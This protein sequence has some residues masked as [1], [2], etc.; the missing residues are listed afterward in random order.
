MRKSLTQ[1]LLSRAGLSITLGCALMLS[2]CSGGSG[3]V[4]TPT[5]NNSTKIRV[6]GINVLNGQEWQ[7]NRALDIQFSR[8]VDFSTVN[9]NTINLMDSQGVS[10]TG[11]FS[12][13]LDSQ[14]N[15]NRRMIRFQ[16]NCPTQADFSDAGL[17][18]D[19]TYRLTVKGSSTGGV[20]LTD[21]S[22]EGLEI[23]A[24]VE[25]NTP[26]SVD[27][28]VLF[29][30]T[31]A[32]PPVVVVRGLNDD[33]ALPASSLVLGGIEQ[34]FL[35]SVVDQEGR[36]LFDVPLN[37]YS[38]EENQLQV[39]LQFNQPID[40][41]AENIN[42]GL[43][44]LQYRENGATDFTDMATELELLANCTERGASLRVSPLGLVPQD[45]DLRVVLFQGFKD[46]T[47]NPTESDFD[48][49]SVMHTVEAGDPNALHPGIDNPEVDDLFETFDLSGNEIGS[50]E[51]I[52]ANSEFPAANW[53]DGVL[54]ASFAFGGTGGP[55]G[56]FD[57]HIPQGTERVL[58][59]VSDT[60]QGGPDGAPV[61]TQAVINGVVDVRNL[62]VPKGSKLRIIGP[63]TCTILASG[64]VEILGEVSVNGSSN[65]GV[66]TL[67]TTNQPEEGAKGNAGGGDGGTGSFLTTQSTPRGGRGFGAFNVP[68]LGGEGGESGYATGTKHN[69]RAGGGG[70]GR[71]GPDIY[72]RHSGATQFYIR[73]QGLVGL[74]A[75]PGAPGGIA[76]TGAISQDGRAQGG[77]I[78]PAPFIDPNPDNNFLGTMITSE[79]DVIPG[80]LFDVHAGAGGGGGGDAVKSNSFP[81]DPFTIIGDEKGAGGGGGAGGLRILAIGDITIGSPGDPGFI[82]ADGGAGGGGENTSYFDR[83]GGGSGGGSGGHVVISTANNLT[84]YGEA[85]ASGGPGPWYRDAENV[86]NHSV[87]PISLVGGQGGAGN[88]SDGGAN[89]NGPTFW[90]CDGIPD[91]YFDGPNGNPPPSGD[92]CFTTQ[93]DS[94]DPSGFNSLAA[95]GDGSPGILQLHVGDYDTQLFFPDVADATLYSAGKDITTVCAPPPLGWK[96]PGAAPDA[97]VPFFGAQ[98]ESQSKWIPLGLARINTGGGLDNLDFTFAGTDALGAIPNTGSGSVAAL[99]AILGPATM[100]SPGYT[101][102][103][104]AAALAAGD[105][106]YKENPRLLTGFAVKLEDSSDPLVFQ[107]YYITAATYA[108]GADEFTFMV[109]PNGPNPATFVAAGTIEASLIQRFVGV[110]TNGIQDNYSDL[111]EITVTFQAAQI[112]PD[113]GLVINESTFVAD[114]DD[115]EPPTNSTHWDL[116]RVNFNFNIDK[117]GLGNIDVATPLPGL[118]H[119]HMHFEF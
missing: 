108:S 85:D 113:T 111:T 71:L 53:G 9:F 45:S 3:G 25:F 78:G 6:T 22:G 7:I 11:V 57:W 97:M 94:A 90:K 98:S 17:L 105:Q 107:N 89:E 75:E 32:G 68:N 118:D 10:A 48:N 8:D 73:V 46:L 70:G 38:I 36:L 99:P 26:D 24:A 96:E 34:E 103:M 74:D 43:V 64:T 80:E 21:T 27:P 109:D 55:N 54:E 104:N 35:W 56:N 115:L 117:A 112:D 72:H 100:A 5:T 47:G 42:T 30:D 61:T 114:V 12:H 67:N 19:R 23:G 92:F 101:M 14:G 15:L 40:A 4:S 87:R 76:G 62:K 13:P 39:V 37:H 41:T 102:T 106:L 77:A 18:P 79:G 49:F 86:A 29:V 84:I 66:G 81:L 65:P 116:F 59:T 50:I 63:N 110:V 91:W 16:P 60:I 83:V 33:P 44:R 69:R 20:A 58:N 2:A 51:D 1:Q 95:G 52:T 28:L 88:A 93:P 119:W 82:S 31:T